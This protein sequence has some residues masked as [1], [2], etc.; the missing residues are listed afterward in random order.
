MNQHITSVV[1]P[2]YTTC[3]PVCSFFLNDVMQLGSVQNA[4]TER[5]LFGSL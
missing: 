3:G 5:V 2:F 4:V 1:S